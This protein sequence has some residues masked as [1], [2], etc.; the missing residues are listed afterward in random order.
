MDA[1][2]FVLEQVGANV[3]RII[4]LIL[5]IETAFYLE[6]SLNILEAIKSLLTPILN[7][8]NNNPLLVPLSAI[9]HNHLVS[10]LSA[11]LYIII[12]YILIFVFNFF[13]ERQIRS[14]YIS[15]PNDFSNRINIFD[16]KAVRFGIGH[17]LVGKEYTID[18]SP[19]RSGSW[20]SRSSLDVHIEQDTATVMY[21][22]YGESKG[23]TFG[24]HGFT[25][26]TLRDDATGDGYW[27]DDKPGCNPKSTLYFKVTPNLRKA[28]L[29]DPNLFAK[30]GAFFPW[31]ND[32]LLRAYAALPQDHPLRKRPARLP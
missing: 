10:I 14:K 20:R 30:V 13:Y 18:S 19:T 21:I 22:H 6:S 9:D 23:S 7:G 31:K 1:R 28:M 11:A 12:L 26:M 3:I 24:G 2:K 17:A 15:L 16:I 5:A 4:A 8:S 29:K 27:I 25:R 32:A